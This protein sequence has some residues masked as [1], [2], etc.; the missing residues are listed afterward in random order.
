[1]HRAELFREI[2]GNPFRPVTFD[3]SW[4]TST[5]VELA[6][7][8]YESRTFDR[9]PILADALQDAGCEEPSVIVHCQSDGPHVRGCWVV[10][11]VLGRGW[12]GAPRLQPVRRRRVNR[13]K[14]AV[15]FWMVIV[16]PRA[17][18]VGM[19][20]ML[21]FVVTLFI[22]WDR[23]AVAVAVAM[24]IALVGVAL[25]TRVAAWEAR[26]RGGTGEEGSGQIEPW[27]PAGP[28]G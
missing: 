16:Y 20:T 6:R 10:D 12:P 3:P 21:A 5:A 22:G 8:M 27:G 23:M 9:M 7:Q 1:L 24:A 26:R 28:H 25:T 2:V 4:R 13:R 17:A 14:E 11:L 19:L 18:A 15:V